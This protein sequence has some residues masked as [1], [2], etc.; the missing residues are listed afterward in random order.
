MLGKYL[1]VIAR[2]EVARKLHIE[3]LRTGSVMKRSRDKWVGRKACMRDEKWL[4]EFCLR[5]EQID[6]LRDLDLNRVGS[7]MNLKEAES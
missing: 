5:A 7:Y 4:Y 2:E 3:E 6:T 1:V